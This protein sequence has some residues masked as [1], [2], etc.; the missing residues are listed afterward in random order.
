[1]SAAGAVERSE[2]SIGPVQMLILGF[3]DCRGIGRQHVT[4]G[5]QG[6]PTVDHKVA[7]PAAR[8]LNENT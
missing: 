4:A 3:E 1:M 8:W 7:N 6:D 5:Y 2:M